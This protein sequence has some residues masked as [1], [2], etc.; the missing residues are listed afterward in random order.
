M[1]A[2]AI[3]KRTANRK[4]GSISLEI[5]AGALVTL[6]LVALALNVSFA[7]LAYG[8]NDRACRDAARAA[9]QQNTAADARNAAKLIVAGF[10]RANSLLGAITVS[11][12]VYNDFKGN[13]PADQ[14]PY[15]TVT[16]RST[17]SMPAP[18]EFFGQ[19]V[20]GTTI[21]VAKTYTFPIVRLSVN[22]SK[23]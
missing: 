7:M 15:V 20:F 22:T 16:T 14:S 11:D 17:V 23:S 10:S 18:I 12:V 5:A 9:A 8:A 4:R 2:F 6:G 21:P 1:R 3:W 19:Q 13:P